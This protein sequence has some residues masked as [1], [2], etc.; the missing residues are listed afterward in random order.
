MDAYNL[1]MWLTIPFALFLACGFLY[2]G[3][4]SIQQIAKDF[5]QTRATSS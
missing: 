1:A 5:A 4:L 2:V 3:I